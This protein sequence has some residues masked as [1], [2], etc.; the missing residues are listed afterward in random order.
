MVQMINLALIKVNSFL[1]DEKGVVMWEYLL[2]IAAVSVGI[3]FAIAFAAPSLTSAVIN[4]TCNAIDTVL[5]G[6]PLTCSGTGAA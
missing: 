2:V 5:P 4:G 3:I 6:T 1:R